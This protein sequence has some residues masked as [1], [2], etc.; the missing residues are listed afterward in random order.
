MVQKN[1]IRDFYSGK[2]IFLTGSSGFVGKFLLEKLLRS[3]AGLK[4]I[5]VLMRG[6]YG[7]SASDRLKTILESSASFLLVF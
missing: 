3:C 5:Y 6:K 1:S 4:K 2:E 7:K